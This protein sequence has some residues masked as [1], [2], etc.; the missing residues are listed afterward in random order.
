MTRHPAGLSSYYFKERGLPYE[1]LLDAFLA[2]FAVEPG[3][4]AETGFN[5]RQRI[6]I[7]GE[8]I[9]AKI[10]R[11]A[12]WLLHRGVEISCVSYQCYRS[13]DDDMLLDF[14]EVVSQ[15]ETPPLS[16]SA[17]STVPASVDDAV[18]R[19]APLARA[20][21]ESLCERACAFGDD[22]QIGVTASYLKLTAGNNFA[23]IQP[24]KDGLRIFVRPEGFT[25]PP[26]GS[27]V[28]TGLLVK[29]VSEKTS[30]SLNHW[31][32]LVNDDQLLAA[33]ELLHRSY[34]AVS[35]LA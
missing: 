14:T 30:W 16:V 20:L 13:D 29:R 34:A 18:R 19:M 17:V 2:T 1:S 5:V 7:V 3:D 28:V 26:D 27:A 9:E 31:F 24:R 4:F 12:R 25:I 11:T 33:A 23:E 21:F 32:V 15:K 8:S 22:V 35:K 10:E 6:L